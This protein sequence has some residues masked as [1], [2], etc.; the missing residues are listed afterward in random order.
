MCGRAS[1]SK[2]NHVPKTSSVVIAIVKAREGCGPEPNK[3]I[4]CEM[5]AVASP[6]PSF[7]SMSM[8]ST[9]PELR[10]ETVALE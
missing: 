4:R 5:S 3:S 2:C 6:G 1:P 8:A 9:S 7:T 10:G